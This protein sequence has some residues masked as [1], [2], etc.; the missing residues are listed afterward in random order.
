MAR[1]QNTSSETK[2]VG[3]WQLNQEPPGQVSRITLSPGESVNIPLEVLNDPKVRVLAE[4]GDFRII[5]VALVPGGPIEADPALRKGD[6][7]LIRKVI[8]FGSFVNDG[9]ATKSVALDLLPTGTMISSVIVNTT[10]AFDDSLALE[11]GSAT[12]PNAVLVSLLQTSVAYAERTNSAAT[13]DYV[14][15]GIQLV[16]LFTC[17]T[18][19]DQQTAG[20]VEILVSYFVC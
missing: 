13:L 17:G 8:A 11:L 5:D 6:A 19:L 12:D 9:T 7:R 14:A 3:G 2:Y 16:A 15:S 18:T 1:L 4:S 20:S 10:A